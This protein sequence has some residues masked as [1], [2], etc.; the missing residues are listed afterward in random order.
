MIVV[1]EGCDGSGKTTLARQLCERY[2]LK[3]H[4][5]GPPPLNVSPLE[6]YGWILEAARW[7]IK[8]GHVRGVVFDRLALGERVYG[9]IYRNDDRL[10]ADGWRVFKRLLAAADA[11]HVVCDPGFNVCRENWGR[12]QNNEMIAEVD[13]LKRVHERYREL[14]AE[15]RDGRPAQHYHFN[16][17]YPQC[18][19]ELCAVINAR[20]YADPIALPPGIIG[21]PN[22]DYLFIGERGSSPDSLTTDLAF[23]GTTGSSHYLTQMLDEAGFREDEIAFVNAERWDNVEVPWHQW[24]FKRFIALGK[25]AS[26]ACRARGVAHW[27]VPHPQY[28]K[29]FRSD[30]PERYIEMLKAGRLENMHVEHHG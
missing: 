22:A 7:N 17:T 27:A 3:Y 13:A 6:H 10:G 12:R 20:L 14:T 9:S 26:E 28:W 25:I 24:P 16:Y 19:D 11:L 21:S 18:F 8:K 30:H 15:I 29:R 1:L 4:H 23:F 2:D 5:E